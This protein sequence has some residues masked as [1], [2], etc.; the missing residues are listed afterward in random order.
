MLTCHVSVHHI[1]ACSNESRCF[2]GLSHMSWNNHFAHMF[3]SL[4]RLYLSFKGLCGKE[5]AVN[6]LWLQQWEWPRFRLL[7]LFKSLSQ[8]SSGSGGWVPHSSF[9]SIWKPWEKVQ[10]DCDDLQKSGEGA[11]CFSA[12]RTQCPAI[13]L[14]QTPGEHVWKV[15]RKSECRSLSLSVWD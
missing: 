7:I 12:V 6:S 14:W 15:Q 8:H 9:S 1:W 10:V 11:L 5:T 13:S 4:L 2:H 3:E